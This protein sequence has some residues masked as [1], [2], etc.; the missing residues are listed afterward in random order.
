MSSFNRLGC[1]RRVWL[2]FLASDDSLIFASKTVDFPP[3]PRVA[4]SAHSR[5]AASFIAHGERDSANHGIKVFLVLLTL[6][7]AAPCGAK[8]DAGTLM[9]DR[10]GQFVCLHRRI[11][12]PEM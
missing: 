9:R 1:F 8:T 12:T 5:E 6:P 4:R 2:D 11:C 10:E 7:N 3:R